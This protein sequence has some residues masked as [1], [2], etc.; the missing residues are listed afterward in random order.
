MCK[1]SSNII[2]L[3]QIVQTLSELSLLKLKT[4]I[5]LTPV[6]LVKKKVNYSHILEA[7]QQHRDISYFVQSSLQKEIPIEY[8]K[9]WTNRK[10]AS[11]DKFLNLVKTVFK[12]DNFLS[13]NT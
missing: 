11:N 1:F 6:E 9:Q 7:Q 2:L 12:T 5:V 13:S 10:Y 4:E 8:L 3:K